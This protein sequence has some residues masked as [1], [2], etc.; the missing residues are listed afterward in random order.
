MF[1]TPNPKIEDELAM[2]Y[3]KRMEKEDNLPRLRYTESQYQERKDD[4]SNLEVQRLWETI[5]ELQ[6]ELK[7]IKQRIED[8]L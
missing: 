7:Q 8:V 4:S 2:E 6:Q 1:R 3:L 5:Y